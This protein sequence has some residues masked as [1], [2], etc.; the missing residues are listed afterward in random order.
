M[1]RTILAALAVALAAPAAAQINGGAIQYT[2][3]A[4][5]GGA[6]TSSLR[7]PAADNCTAP[8]YSFTGQTTSGL[9]SPVSGTLALRIGGVNSY[10]F[11]AGRIVV[12]E[13]T[14]AEPSIVSTAT[15]IGFRYRGDPFY[16]WGFAWGS[17][18][19]FVMTASGI[20]M[21]AVGTYGFSSNVAGAN[22][23]DLILSRDAAATLQLGADA[24]TA[25]AQTIKG[26]DSTGATIAGGSLTLKGGAGTSGIA[27]GG[28]LIL[29]GGANSS[30]G[31]PGA[32]AISDGGT[33][34]TC[35]AARRGS[36]WYDAGGAGA[37]DTFEVCRKDA[38][39]VYAWVTLF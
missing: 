39:N 4:F 21:K 20:S 6:I 26:S 1:K 19:T 18:E 14:A 13:G 16:Y 2:P 3:P 35:D 29:A 37:A 17:A 34:P 28:A 8:P 33:K 5:K 11:T 23:N 31:E 15:N 32:V 10:T 36:G 25:V 12:P 22:A 27:N 7:A 9:C 38:S 30:T 24:A